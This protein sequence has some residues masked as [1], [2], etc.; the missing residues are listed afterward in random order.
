VSSLAFVG[1]S[2]DGIVTV[3]AHRTEESFARHI[4]QATMPRK[5]ESLGPQSSVV[6]SW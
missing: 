5:V 3:C 6:L 4:F 2:L 1:S